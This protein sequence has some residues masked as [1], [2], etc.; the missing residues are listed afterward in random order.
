MDYTEIDV[1]SEV[2]AVV[3]AVERGEFRRATERESMAV[4][5]AALSKIVHNLQLRVESDA[6]LS[7]PVQA[8]A[9]A[10]V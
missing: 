6:S 3:K 10:T 9:A 8:R 4:R 1:E 7:G 2:A 5:L